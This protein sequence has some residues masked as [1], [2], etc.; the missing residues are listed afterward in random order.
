MYYDFQKLIRKKIKHYLCPN[1]KKKSYLFK[2]KKDL[3]DMKNDKIIVI[4]YNKHIL[5]EVLINKV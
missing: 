4:K 1:S 2:P 3:P 5:N